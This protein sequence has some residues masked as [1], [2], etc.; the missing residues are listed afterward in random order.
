MKKKVLSAGALLHDR[1]MAACSAFAAADGLAAPLSEA[2]KSLRR[3]VRGRKAAAAV[4]AAVPA[5][6]EKM[7]AAQSRKPRVL[8]VDD[9]VG[10]SS[11]LADCLECEGYE[12]R[13]ASSGA[14]G[15]KAALSFLPD[16]LLLDYNLGDMNGHDVAVAVKNTRKTSRIPFL[17]LSAHGADPLM[18]RAFSRLPNCRGA[19]S[20]VLPTGEILKAVNNAMRD[21]RKHAHVN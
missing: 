9:N 10:L 5:A 15:I 6:P 16:L 2:G 1:L 18:A 21:A 12:A 11:V 14:A 17:V 19:M 8:I 4:P 13:T 7:A 20:K 3:L